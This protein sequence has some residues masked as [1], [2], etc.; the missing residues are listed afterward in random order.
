[1]RDEELRAALHAEAEAVSG[2]EIDTR[3]IVRSSRGRRVAR[4]LAAGGAMS[5]LVLGAGAG[6]MVSPLLQQTASDSGTVNVLEAP[7][8]RDGAGASGY[9][10]SGEGSAGGSM[11]AP[12]YKVNGCGGPLA[13][14]TEEG[15]FPLLLDVEFPD[16]APVGD[17]VSGEVSVTNIGNETISGRMGQVAAMTLSQDGVVLWHTPNATLDAPVAL[18]PGDTVLIDATFEPEMC[19]PEDE[20][21]PGFRPGLP[22]VPAGEYQLSAAL[23]VTVGEGFV[24]QLV[25]EPEPIT[26]R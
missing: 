5:V 6:I 26:L 19:A 24:M 8:A 20:G 18:E 10:E 21:V 13:T 22:K 12:A 7:A 23:D 17:T 3:R 2:S 1:M 11:L 14:A 4:K 25:S 9:T 15:Q 16:A